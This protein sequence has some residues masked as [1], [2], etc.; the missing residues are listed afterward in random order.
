MITLT[1]LHPVQSTAV[2]TWKF[3]QHQVIR[4]GRAVDNEVVLY[5][6]VVS[7]H[8][9]ELQWV[10]HQ[11]WV[12]NVGSNGTYLDG[13]KVQ[14]E[15][16]SDGSIIR[17]ARS[18][19]NIKVT[20]APEDPVKEALGHPQQANSAMELT[21]GAPEVRSHRTT[22]IEPL[23]Q[24]PEAMA[25][26][27]PQNITEALS[28]VSPVSSSLDDRCNHERSPKSAL[29]C[30]DCGQ[31]MN[32]SHAIGAYQILKPL[33]SAG[34][35]FQGWKEKRTYVLRTIHPDYRGDLA[36][37]DG[38]RKQLEQCMQLNHGAIPKMVE[39]VEFE[40]QPYLVYEMIYGQTL[41]KWVNFH[42]A[43]SLPQVISF[44]IEIAHVLDYLHGRDPAFVHQSIKP[45]NLIRPTIPQGMLNLILVNF[46]Q[47]NCAEKSLPSFLEI[48]YASANQQ[49]GKILPENDLYG[50]GMTLI[51]ML[52]GNDPD[53]YMRL[54]DNQFSLCL[55]DVPNLQPD[56]KQF[57]TGLTRVDSANQITSPKQAIDQLQ[58]L[59]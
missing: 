18:G 11:W 5:S 10:D 50:L 19:P 7:R 4:I 54:A 42:G 46:G 44:G 33:G 21:L 45:S 3:E 51:F 25:P 58:Q 34:N 41:A 26:G 59:I 53:T 27:D 36:L 38:F 55:D 12:K 20:I 1:L 22:T 39:V 56:F 37:V 28:Q 6:A 32:V 31:P 57:I 9:V 23:F 47:V 17:L 2:Q 35:T 16:L 43:L 49:A 29:I 48:S 15:C 30:I 24:D 13:R 40:N 14:S 52:T 8:H